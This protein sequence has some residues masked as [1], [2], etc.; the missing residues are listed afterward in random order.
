MGKKRIDFEMIEVVGW[1]CLD[2][3]VFFGGATNLLKTMSISIFPAR[4]IFEQIP[5]FLP[6]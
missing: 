4:Q 2:G 1:W 3:L 5:Q 6:L